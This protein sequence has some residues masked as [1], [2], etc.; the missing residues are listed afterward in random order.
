MVSGI[1]QDT[2]LYGSR[3]LKYISDVS[4]CGRSA[5]YDWCSVNDFD[6]DSFYSREVHND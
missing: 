2:I 5:F 3:G 4:E 1:E 6:F